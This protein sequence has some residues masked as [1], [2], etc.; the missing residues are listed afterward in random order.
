VGKQLTLSDFFKVGQRVDVQ[1]VSKGK[2][3]AGVMKRYNFKGFKATHGV[4]EYYR[5]GGSIGTRLTPG[6]TFKGKKM[7][8]HM[9]DAKLTV[10][11]LF[12]ERI[13]IERHLLFLRGGV[14]GADGGIVAVRTALKK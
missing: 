4:H 9:G 6:M 11:N 14:P 10:Q 12:V 3:F 2:G 8:G 13:D 7:P 1:G 5:H